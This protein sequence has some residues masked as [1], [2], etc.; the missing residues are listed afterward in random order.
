MAFSHQH[1]HIYSPYLASRRN[2]WLAAGDI[3]KAL[4]LFHIHRWVSCNVRTNI[5]DFDF[6]CTLSDMA[7]SHQHSHIYSPYLASN[8]MRGRNSRLTAGDIHKALFLF[9][10]H[11]W[12]SCIGSN[13]HQRFWFPLHSFGLGINQHSHV[14]SPFLASATMRGRNSWSAAGNTH[15]TTLT[16]FSTIYLVMCKVYT[17]VGGIN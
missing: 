14:Y 11:R 5:S 4:F 2:A 8:T 1:S 9:H 17:D 16:N 3:H 10:I 7:F 13:K 12:V 6:H 15:Y